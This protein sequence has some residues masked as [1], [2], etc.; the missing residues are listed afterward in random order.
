VILTLGEKLIF[1]IHG[2][3]IIRFVIILFQMSA[4]DIARV[5]DF[6]LP[7]SNVNSD[8]SQLAWQAR[9]TITHTEV[10]TVSQPRCFTKAKRQ[11]ALQCVRFSSHVRFARL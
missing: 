4:L 11:S 10:A 6:L 3:A 7:L 5:Y 1:Y 2:F 8:E 9:R